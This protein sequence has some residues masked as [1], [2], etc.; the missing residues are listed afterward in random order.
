MSLDRGLG[1]VVV[2]AGVV[3]L[4]ATR[5]LPEAM[6]GDP[7][8]PSLF[9]TFLS[10]ALIGLGVLVLLRPGPGLPPGQR[11]WQGGWRLTAASVLLVAYAFLLEPLGYLLATAAVLLALLALY[12]PGRWLVNGAVAL[13]F[14]AAS[15]Y[16]FHKLLGVFVPKGVVG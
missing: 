8:G 4:V 7:A 1:A 15:W 14:T 12:N 2:A 3:L 16:L 13:G 10:W 9:P 6:M 5:R 11:L